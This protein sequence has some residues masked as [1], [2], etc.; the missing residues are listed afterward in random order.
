MSKEYFTENI[1]K[2]TLAKLIDET[3]SY[4]KNK[5]GERI[6]MSNLFK[7]ISAAAAVVLVI[8]FMNIM[9]PILS[10]VNVEPAGP[11]IA[12]TSSEEFYTPVVTDRGELFLPE[13]IEKSFF[14][15]KILSVITD[16]K[17]AEKMQ[18]YYTLKDPSASDLTDRAKEDMLI[19]YPI[20]RF[21]LIYALDPDISYREKDQLLSYIY[22]YTN[23]TRS[24][25]IQMCV[26]IEY[27]PMELDER[28][29]NVR[30]GKDYDTLL[31]DIEWYDYNT[32]FKEVYT[33]LM[34]QYNGAISSFDIP[35]EEVSRLTDDV[36]L[37]LIEEGMESI[38]EGKMYVPRL[39]NGK[40]NYHAF[41]VET[42]DISQF[43]DSNGYYIYNIYPYK[44][45]IYYTDE[46]G[47]KQYKYFYYANNELPVVNSKKEYD[48]LLKNEIIPYCDDLLAQGLITQLQYDY[49]TIQDPLNYFVSLWFD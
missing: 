18:A 45:Y 29:K 14:E 39:V 32:Y 4:E 33:P 25:L 48:Y 30:F 44:P 20:C 41:A 42:S 35:I 26:N 40:M 3:L 11:E 22:E 47:I 38:K 6:K 46:N 43:L 24:E 19:T 16:Q 5:K 27:L 12:G 21:N 28:Y 7:I 2:E 9:L 8:G 34:V 23:I 1:S 13:I 31:L 17:V 10:N 49:F 37:A 36:A 15:D